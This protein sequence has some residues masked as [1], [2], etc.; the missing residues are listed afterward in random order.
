MNARQRRAHARLWPLLAA[1]MAIVCLAA[2]AA[3]S[4]W[5]INAAPILTERPG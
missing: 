4:G 3:R 5:D 1:L 2:L